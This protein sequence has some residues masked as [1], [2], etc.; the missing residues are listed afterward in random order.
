MRLPVHR[1]RPCPRRAATSLKDTWSRSDRPPASSLSAWHNSSTFRPSLVLKGSAPPPHKAL[2][3]LTVP[4]KYH[5]DYHDR[6]S[7]D[8]QTNQSASGKQAHQVSHNSQNASSGRKLRGTDEK[9]GAH[10]GRTGD[11]RRG[12]PPQGR[13]RPQRQHRGP[14]SRPGNDGRRRPAAAPPRPSARSTRCSPMPGTASAGRSSTRTSRKC[15]T[16]STPT[17]PAPST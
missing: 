16:S 2:I 6:G 3:D 9:D 11:R 8:Y 15:G 4:P 14:S 5:S 1:P 10:G 7:D 12:P 17:S 13:R